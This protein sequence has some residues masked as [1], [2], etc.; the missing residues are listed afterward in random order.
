MATVES[1]EGFQDIEIVAIDLTQSEPPGKRMRELSAMEIAR[2]DDPLL[3]SVV[4]VLSGE[5][6]EGWDE[7]LHR[8]EA[9]LG[10]EGEFLSE[11]N[12]RRLL[13]DYDPERFDER[14]TGLRVSVANANQQY[15]EILHERAENRRRMDEAGARYR[16]KIAAAA[17]RLGIRTVPPEGV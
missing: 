7:C 6:P 14:F 11:L 15:R 9:E 16:E 3:G 10:Y 4:F 13:L 12:G 8:S 2:H 1:S 17:E 5:P